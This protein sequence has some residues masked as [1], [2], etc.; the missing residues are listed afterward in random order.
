MLERIVCLLG[1]HSWQG[2]KSVDQSPCRYTRVCEVCGKQELLEKHSWGNWRFMSRYDCDQER[3]CQRCGEHEERSN[4]HW[5]WQ[6]ESDGS[7]VQIALCRRC[8]TIDSAN[9]TQAPHQWDVWRHQSPTSCVQVRICRRCG[10]REEGDEI[11][12][13]SEWQEG[14]DGRQRRRCVHCGYQESEW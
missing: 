7:C 13:W 8:N 1:R 14:P 6:Y 3:E 2:W 11:H 12:M 4:H 9:R 5:A 10:T